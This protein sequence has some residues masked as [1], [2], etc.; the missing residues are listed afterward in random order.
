VSEISGNNIKIQT[1][2][3]MHY[4]YPAL[5]QQ[6]RGVSG[7]SRSSCLVGHRSSNKKDSN[8]ME[9]ENQLWKVIL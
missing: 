3:H 9:G 8:K 5:L 1:C 2:F 7:N 4:Y 6:G